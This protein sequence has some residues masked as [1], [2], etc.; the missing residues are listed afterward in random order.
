MGRVLAQS[1]MGTAC[2]RP[3]IDD[4]APVAH[5]R[6][7]LVRRLTTAA[8]IGLAVVFM[9]PLFLSCPV[10]GGSL[11]CVD[12]RPAG[13]RRLALLRRGLGSGA[14]G[15]GRLPSVPVMGHYRTRAR[16]VPGRRRRSPRRYSC[17]PSSGCRRRYLREWR[18]RTGGGRA[19]GGAA[20]ARPQRQ[21]GR[22]ARGDDAGDR[23]RVLG[24]PHGRRCPAYA[25]PVPAL[26]PVG[27]PPRA[28]DRAGPCWSRLLALT[29]YQGAYPLPLMLVALG[30]DGLWQLGD[31]HERRGLF[32]ALPIALGLF[33]CWRG[34]ACPCCA[35]CAST[36]GWSAR[37]LH[38]GGRGVRH[39]QT[40]SGPSRGTN[41]CGRST[42]LRGADPDVLAGTV[43]ALVGATTSSRA[44]RID[45][46][47]RCCWSGA[48][49]ATSG[50]VAVR[51][52]AC[53]C[54]RVAAR[55]RASWRRRQW[56][57]R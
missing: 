39:P 13:S 5:R 29:V 18:S 44:R 20:I 23:D 42:R 24:A 52:L 8:C 14:R 53:S 10:V 47:M 50:A 56:R 43:L 26:A 12:R 17:S 46:G 15:A 31:A 30:A 34:R 1:R 28:R 11:R 41:T 51:P 2:L 21:R 7:R 16:A 3:G 33:R 4:G 9:I 27:P 19:R 38:D 54:A 35:T 6:D 32:V 49:W 48:R 55:P 40:H 57:S 45:L 25:Q 36:R 22:A 37:R